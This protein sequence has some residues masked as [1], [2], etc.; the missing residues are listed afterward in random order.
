MFSFY[1]YK[2]FN[3]YLLSSIYIIHDKNATKRFQGGKVGSIVVS[4]FSWF[5]I[6]YFLSLTKDKMKSLHASEVYLLKTIVFNKSIK[7]HRFGKVN[8]FCISD[9]LC[10]PHSFLKTWLKG[11]RKHLT[12]SIFKYSYLLIIGIYKKIYFFI[13]SIFCA[14][15]NSK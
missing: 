8:F 13:I 2:A 1:F 7:S 12:F 5:S 3:Q 9:F 4:F 14:P 11:K 15:Q 6:I 10:N